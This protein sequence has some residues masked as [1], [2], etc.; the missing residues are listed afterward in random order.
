M[1]YECVECVECVEWVECVECVV[2][3]FAL[4]VGLSFVEF[5]NFAR[6]VL[7][8]HCSRSPSLY[9]MENLYYLPF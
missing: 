8:S 6:E 2:L 1:Y 9:Y 4:Y 7:L 5:R 3:I